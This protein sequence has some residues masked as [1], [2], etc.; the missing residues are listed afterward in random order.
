MEQVAGED[1]TPFFD[2]WLYRGGVPR[3]SGTWTWDAAAQTVAVNLRQTQ[4][5]APFRIPV[6]VA[7]QVPGAPARVERIDMT[8]ASAT[9]TFKTTQEP[10]AI[11]LDPGVR[12]LAATEMS[13]R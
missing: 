6:E 13:R 4:P 8:T 2:Q 7:L 11:V 12:L 10:G 3:L 1:L 9:A 5:G